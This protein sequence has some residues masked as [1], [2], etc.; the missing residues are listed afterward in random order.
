MH[1]SE[2]ETAER[3]LKQIDEQSERL[4]QL[5]LGM[6]QLA[7][8]ESGQQVLNLELLDAR[9]V[10][11]DV[12][13]GF[14]T[15]ADSRS[16]VLDV[17]GANELYLKTDRQA[18]HTIL[19]NLIDNALKHTFADGRVTVELTNDTTGPALCVRDTGTGIRKNCSAESSSDFI[20][21]KKI[22]P[23]NVA[24]P[25]W[26]LPSSSIS[27]SPL[28]L[29]SRFAANWDEEASSRFRSRHLLPRSNAAFALSDVDK[30][31]GTNGSF[32]DVA[33]R[34]HESCR[35]DEDDIVELRFAC[36]DLV[37]LNIMADS[38]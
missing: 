27:V 32:G 18:L 12:V 10:V 25:V 17:V 6:L 19:S 31:Q 28:M 20:A 23:A 26:G 4:L 8:V 14:A 3:F 1:L 35:T 24:G 7:R 2:P 30:P 21:S 37:S 38:F 33:L 34:Q 16:V 9:D 29:A 36:H 22:D 11:D 15:V 13:R 5:I